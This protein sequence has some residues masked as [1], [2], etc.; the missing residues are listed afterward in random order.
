[1]NGDRRVGDG[2]VGFGGVEGD[3]RPRPRVHQHRGP[4]RC[5][6]AGGGDGGLALAARDGRTVILKLQAHRAGGAGIGGHGVIADAVHPRVHQGDVAGAGRV[7]DGGPFQH[8]VCVEGGRIALAAQ[9]LGTRVG[10]VQG[11]QRH[12]RAGGAG[13]GDDKRK[14]AINPQTMGNYKKI[15]SIT[16]R[17]EPSGTTWAAFLRGQAGKEEIY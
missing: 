5:Q 14:V 9:G 16:L 4:Q 13:R 7:G 17:M 15:K 8:R 10:G 6:V 11:V 12:G 2:G 1:M 3:D